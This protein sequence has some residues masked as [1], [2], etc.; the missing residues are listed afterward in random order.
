MSEDEERRK[1]YKVG[2]G[3]PLEEGRLPEPEPMSPLRSLKRL[4]RRLLEGLW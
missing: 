2:H 3:P 1:R 4:A